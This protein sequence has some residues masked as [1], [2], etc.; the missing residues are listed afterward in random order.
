MRILF[1]GDIFG[2]PGRRALAERLSS[3]IDD[4]SVDVCIANGENAA[5][6]RGITANLFKKL[7]KYGVHVITGGNHSFAIP[8]NDKIFMDHPAILRPHNYP[9]GNIGKGTTLF[10]LEDGRSIGVVNLQGRTFFH[11]TLDCP[12]RMGKAAIKEL[13][14]TTPIIFVDFHA[15]AS[16]EKI[17]LAWHVDGLATAVV[18]THTHVQTADE[19]ILPGGTAFITDVGMTGP[20]NSCIGMKPEGVIKRFLL[21]TYAR[22]EPSNSSPMINGVIIDADDDT[23]KALSISRIFERLSL[24]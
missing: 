16:S 18:G 22:F 2:N 21:Q 3:L 15:E 10:T 14:E 8:D 24:P 9:P 17:A 13:R 23:G 11:E 6:G 20:E 4:N 19:H 12:F 7:R 1:I 5:G